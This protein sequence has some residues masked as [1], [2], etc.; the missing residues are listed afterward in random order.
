MATGD[1][2]ATRIN[3]S[4]WYAEIDIEGLS[5]GGSYDTGMGT[6]N[7]PTS[8]KIKFNV[9]SSSYTDVGVGSNMTRT[10]Y[11]TN[12]KRKVYPNDAN[13][14]ESLGTGIVTVTVALSEWIYSSDTLTVDIYSGFYTES[15]TPNNAASVAAVTN[16]SAEA[17]PKVIGNWS[18]PP[19][20]RVTGASFDLRCVAFHR[21]AQ[22]GRPVKVVKFTVTDE[23]SNTVTAFVTNPI[24]DPSMDD[25]VSVI[26][27]VGTISTATLVQGDTL[28]CNFQAFPWYGDTNATLNTADGVNT[29]P[30]PYYAPHYCLCDKNDTYGI[31]IA[32]VDS[33]S[34]NNSTGAVVDEGSFDDQNPPNAYLNIYA[35]A[36]AIAAYNNTNHSRNDVGGGIIYLQEGSHVWTGGT[37]SAGTTPDCY[38]TITKF[39]GTTQSNVLIS[40]ASGSKDITDR[41]K[42]ESIK[43]TNSTT[44]GFTGIGSLWIHDCIIDSTGAATFYVNSLLYITSCD[45]YNCAE[46]TPYSTTNSPRCL[47]RGCESKE[48]LGQYFRPYTLI[49]N[50]LVGA[51]IRANY[52]GQTSPVFKDTIY[53]FNIVSQLS[54]VPIMLEGMAIIQNVFER[55]VAGST[56][57]MQI[58]ADSSSSDPVNN[59]F[60]WYNT[61]VGQRSNIAYNDCN[62]NG[63]GPGWREHWSVK[64]NIFDDYNC[65]TDIDSHGGTPG[66]ERYGNHSII[67]GTGFSGDVICNRVGTVDYENK[68]LGLFSKRGNPLAPA[69]VDDKSSSG[70]GTGGGNYKLTGSSPALNLV[71]ENKALLP[72][73]LAGVTRYNDGSGAVGAYEYALSWAGKFIGVTN[74]AKI[75]RVSVADINKVIGI[76]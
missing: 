54:D 17:Y 13:A 62:L 70:T 29:L 52:V 71:A 59:V 10:V 30:T 36:N 68:F 46:F 72:Y 6:D 31:T 44:I 48:T 22:E 28:T 63:V 43:I 64:N 75:N 8:G 32:V 4:G 50:D 33:V 49:G 25:T 18:W 56:P 34:G 61:M 3:V 51:R 12:Y 73:D 38:V 5:T 69:F 41:V 19:Y 15:G 57:L 35:A 66:P 39:P 26:E 55:T 27:Y 74:P 11:G 20:T 21:S 58:A 7:D 42:I 23:S 24:I 37:V 9:T 45:L 76:S 53:A 14:D 2:T 65:V 67:H 16:N 40:S 1:I 47:I 60:L